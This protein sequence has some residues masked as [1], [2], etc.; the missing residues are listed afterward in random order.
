M[1]SIKNTNI[2]ADRQLIEQLGGPTKLAKQLRLS[3]THPVQRV[4]NW[5]VRGIPSAVKVQHPALF[6]PNWLASHASTA[7]AATENVAQGV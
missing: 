4:Q 3:G 5:M 7:Q 6:M 2:K 1:P